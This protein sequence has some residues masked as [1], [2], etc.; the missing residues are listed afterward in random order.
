MRCHLHYLTGRADDRLT[1]DLQ[2]EIAAAPGLPDRPGSRGVERFMK[3][4]YLHA[5]TVGD[6]TAHLLRGARGQPPAQAQARARCGRRLRPR[7]LEGFRLDGERLAVGGADAFAKDPVAILRLF[8]VAQE[9]DLDIHPA[10]LAADHARTSGWST[11]C[12]PIPRPTAC[13]WRC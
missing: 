13:S 1:F 2:R 5:K 12:A 3:H 11:G 8:H 7:E 6:L 9:N 10:T 4:Y